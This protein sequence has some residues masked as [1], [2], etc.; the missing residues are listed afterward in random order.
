MSETVV[1]IAL[2]VISQLLILSAARFIVGLWPSLREY[3]VRVVLM[4][5]WYAVMASMII[6]LRDQLEDAWKMGFQRGWIEGGGAEIDLETRW[7]N[8]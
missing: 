7:K 5:A 1:T 3:S 2:L 6:G 8:G 4:L